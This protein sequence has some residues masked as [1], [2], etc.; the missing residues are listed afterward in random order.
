[1]N[2]SKQRYIEVHAHWTDIPHPI[3]MGA[4]Y[5]TT[6][7]AK[8]IFSFTYHDSWLKST[9]A[10]TIDPSLQLF[11]GP[12]YPPCGNENFG[13]F[14]D[15]SPDRWGRFLMDRREA[16]L[17][18]E[19]GRKERQLL[20]SD[21]LLGVYSEKANKI[22]QEVVSAVKGWR[23]EANSLGISAKEQDRMA[24]AFRIGDE[25]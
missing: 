8:E 4:L 9:Q 20:E 13:V 15:S 18:R 19:Q 3:L 11:C 17:A 5:A 12:Q 2:K 1:M 21:Y 25:K 24:R 22:I 16:Q 14:L 10:H 23:K 7:R 6:S